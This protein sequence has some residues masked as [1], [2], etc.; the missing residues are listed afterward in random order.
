MILITG[1]TGYI[2]RHLV[3]RLVTRGDRPH[4]LVRNIDR[5]AQILPAD[6]V[7]IIT[8]DTIKPESLTA[9]VQGR[10]TIVHA[11]FIT[12]DHKEAPGTSYEETNVM[13]TQHLIKAA[14]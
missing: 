7:D 11:A 1:A 14:Q 13:G 12:A 9:A 6:K 3:S 8:G 10:D 4:C 5:A 2:G